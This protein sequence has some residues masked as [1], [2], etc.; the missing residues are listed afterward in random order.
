[1]G[2]KKVLPQEN[3]Q[4]YDCLHD[5]ILIVGSGAM[6]CLFAARLSQA[7]IP[8]TMLSSW[9]EGL[10]RLREGGVTLVDGAGQGHSF[11]VRATQDPQECRPAHCALVLVKSWQ[12]RRAAA[13]L[14]NCLVEDGVALTLQ[15][16]MGN[17][18]V[19]SE[20]LGAQRVALGVTTV[21][22]NL[23]GPGQVRLAGEGVISLGVHNRLAGVTAALRQAG[24]VVESAPDPDALMWGKLVI[25][26]AIN[27]LTALLR[28]SNG[29]L[30][31][32]PTARSLL[33]SL[34]REAAAVAV[35]N[36]IPLPY[37][38]PVVAV[39]NIARK[40]AENRSSM[41]QDVSRGAPT[42][43]DAISGAIVQAGEQ[44]DVPTPLTRAMW[45]LVKALL[46]VAG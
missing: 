2:M 41:L 45:H 42:E 14:F 35:A 16:G 34:A 21:A 20:A 1:M 24:F 29:E 26:A 25:N 23:L 17:R 18:E 32:R 8:V 28:V 6:A 13:Q 9:Q 3:S 19:L 46:P 43:I 4:A 37:P 40:T 15:N 36:G 7:G 31:S 5:G 44:V 33:A 10:S 27:P 12:T 11:P 39:E 30:I 22:A 38:D